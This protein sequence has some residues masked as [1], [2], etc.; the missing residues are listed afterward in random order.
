MATIYQ[1]TRLSRR[2]IS[3]KNKGSALE[4]VGASCSW[5]AGLTAQPFDRHLLW[6]PALKCGAARHEVG[7]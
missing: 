4:E 6:K 7:H 3:D 5:Q 2:S 1:V